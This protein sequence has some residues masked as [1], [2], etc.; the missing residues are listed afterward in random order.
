MLH[1]IANDN[2]FKTWNS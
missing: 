2:N 1:Y